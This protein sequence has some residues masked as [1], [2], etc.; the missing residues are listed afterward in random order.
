MA[1]SLPVSICV[2]GAASDDIAPDYI[3]AGMALGEGIAKRGWRLVF[4]AGDTGMMGAVLRGVKKEDG[5]AVG[6]AP[7]FFNEP[8][9]LSDNLDD[10]L[11]VRTMRERKAFMESYASAFV[12][13]PGGIGTLEEFFEVLVLKQLHQLDA[14]IALLNTDGFF[15]PLPATLDSMRE[16]GFVSDSV[17]DLFAVFETPDD[18]LNWLEEQLSS[19][20]PDQA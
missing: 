18:L 19:G 4:G 6:I 1:Q 8:G 10:L 9:V 11:L 5:K 3:Q 16:K 17:F 15:D 2:Y 14:P 7:F 13:S 20:K 12:M